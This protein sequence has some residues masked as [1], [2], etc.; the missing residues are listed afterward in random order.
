MTTVRVFIE[1]KRQ[2][3]K[4]GITTDFLFIIKQKVTHSIKYKGPG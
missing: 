4:C 1:Q 2:I 3:E